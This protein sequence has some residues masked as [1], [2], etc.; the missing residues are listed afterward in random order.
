[1]QLFIAEAGGRPLGRIAAI[2]DALHNAIH[3]DNLCFFGFFEA[4]SAE[5]A[6]ALLEAAADWARAL[7]RVA[8][9]GPVNPTMNDSCGLLVQGFDSAPYIMMP[10][11]PPSYPGYLE[12]AGLTKVKDVYA[13]R[14]ETARGLPERFVRLATR[15][16]ERYGARVRPVEL[17][18]F[19]EELARVKQLYSAAWEKNWGFVPYTD[20]EF[21]HLAKDLRRLID[22]ELALF[23]ELKGEVVG[24]ALALPDANQL[25]KRMNGRLFPV[26]IWHLLWAQRYIDQARLSILGVLPEY[27]YRG[28][29]LVL[30][31]EIYRRGAARGYRRGECSWVLEDNVAMNEGI[32][33]AGCTLDKVYR[34]YQR[35]L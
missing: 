19:D 9:R 17:R 22:P 30:I 29:E 31:E 28:L 32:K 27:R 24:L 11:N 12:Q 35:A 2:D 16:R 10:Y 23:I 14:F 25:F 6:A 5:V 26:G 13:W 1:M 8:L 3:G 4:S 15:A 7:G 33:A 34:L 18:R 21:A 20:A